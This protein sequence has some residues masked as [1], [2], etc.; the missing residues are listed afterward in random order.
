MPTNIIRNYGLERFFGVPPDDVSTEGL[1]AEFRASVDTEELALAVA[2][3]EEHNNISE[4]INNSS[5][6]FE[7]APL[8]KLQESDKACF[9]DNQESSILH[10]YLST[11]ADMEKE[12][13][14]IGFWN[15]RFIASGSPKDN[16]NPVLDQVEKILCAEA[17]HETNVIPN[18]QQTVG[19]HQAIVKTASET[20]NAYETAQWLI[21]NN[22]VK[23]AMEKLFFYDGVAYQPKSSGDAKRAILDACRSAVKVSGKSAFVKQVYDLLMLEPRIC[24]DA[25]VQLNIV[26]FDDCLLDLDNW[27]LLPHTPEIFVTTHLKGSYQ[28]GVRQGC[29]MFDAFLDSISLGDPLLKKR[30]WEVLGSC[31]VPDQ[32]VKSFP[33][34]QGAPNSGKSVYGNFARG[35]FVGDVVSALEINDLGGNFVLSDLVAKKLCLDL[36]LPADP[37]S[38]R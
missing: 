30:L 15:S 7:A 4:A 36:D 1:E 38:K 31:I 14:P 13:K 32:N 25:D 6:F 27:Q 17:A 28:I 22:H 10:D 9:Q 20:L 35:C 24:C 11:Q 29:P 16:F 8:K 18:S 21:E 26:A 3:A 2:E 12:M 5:P 23:Q 37:F 33:V 19:T 34:L